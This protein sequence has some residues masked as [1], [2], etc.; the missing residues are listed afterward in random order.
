MNESDSN[1][2]PFGVIKTIQSIII[3]DTI[4]ASDEGK[5]IPID[6]YVIINNK[7]KEIESFDE[8]R[9]SIE[10]GNRKAKTSN[11]SGNSFLEY[12]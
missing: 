10:D 8:L 7:T 11:I 9:D 2:D 12:L 4:R 1:A 5:P 3:L 6:C